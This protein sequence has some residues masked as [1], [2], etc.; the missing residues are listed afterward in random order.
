MAVVIRM[1]RMGKRNRPFYRIGACDS[2]A[3][4]DGKVIENLGTYDP[5]IKEEAKKAVLKKDRV[6]YWLGVG[7]RPSEKVGV[8]L[9]KA[10]IKVKK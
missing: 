4:R 2:R 9:K 8:L 3:P 5:Y 6:E 1:K 7:A 10:G